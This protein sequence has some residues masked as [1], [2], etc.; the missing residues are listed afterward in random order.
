MITESPFKLSA[1]LH[2]AEIPD[3]PGLHRLVATY[4]TS[5]DYGIAGRPFEPTGVTDVLIATFDHRRA[6]RR[7]PP[8]SLRSATGPTTTSCGSGTG[9]SGRCA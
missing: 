6:G 8:R 3:D 2:L 1:V 9:S 4:E 7:S 5:S